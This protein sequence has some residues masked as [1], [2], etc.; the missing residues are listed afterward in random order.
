MI[1]FFVLFFFINAKLYYF[2]GSQHLTSSWTSLFW[3][4]AAAWLERRSSPSDE[5]RKRSTTWR[6]R[7]QHRRRIRSSD[8]VHGDVDH[9]LCSGAH[10]LVS[11]PSLLQPRPF[12]Q[13]VRSFPVS[14][15]LSF[16]CC[17][18]CAWIWCSLSAWIC[19]LRHFLDDQGFRST[20]R[21]IWDSF[22]PWMLASIVCVCVCLFF[23]LW[24]SV[25]S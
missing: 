7:S 3:C 5:R 14:S 9:L 1:T 16:S 17:F 19:L 25:I 24:K 22:G 2:S 15:V 12:H 4:D 10:C 8:G 13:F 6:R 18:I 21:A 11:R 23:L 20:M